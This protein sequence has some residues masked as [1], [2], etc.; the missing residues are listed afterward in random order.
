METFQKLVQIKADED[1]VSQKTIASHR[2]TLIEDPVE[3]NVAEESCWWMDLLGSWS[4]LSRT[5]V[6]I[7]KFGEFCD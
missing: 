2:D 4:C 5:D 6:V 1:N 7:Q 3:T